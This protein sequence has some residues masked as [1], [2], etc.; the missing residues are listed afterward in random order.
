MNETKNIKDSWNV[1]NHEIGSWDLL[2][3]EK[4]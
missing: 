1:A 4:Y 2:I 3:A